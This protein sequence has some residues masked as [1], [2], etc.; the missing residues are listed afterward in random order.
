MKKL[1]QVLAIEKSLKGRVATKVSE[2]GT[3]A[4]KEELLTGFNKKYEPLVDGGA[5]RQPETKRVQSTSRDIFQQLSKLV[6]E[7]ITTTALKDTANC[8]ATADVRVNGE[9]ILA[10]V[11]ATHLLFL[12]KQL[13]ELHNFVQRT[14]ELSQDTA[15][16][17][18]PNTGYFRSEEITTRVQEKE[19]VPLVLTEATEHHPAQVTMVSKTIDVGTWNTVRLSGALPRPAKLEILDKINILQNAVKEALEE[20][21][22]VP[23]PEVNFGSKVMDYLFANVTK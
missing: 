7:L 12:D 2:L 6:G 8:S 17:Y 4:Q 3:I 18:D 23:V 13:T 9:V 19:Q 11:P 1:N 5:K 14:A 21:N 10:K 22:S 16:T 20:A 15:W